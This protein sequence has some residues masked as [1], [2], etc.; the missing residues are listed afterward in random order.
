[1]T[2]TTAAIA[3]SDAAIPADGQAAPEGAV[4]SLVCGILSFIIPIIGFILAIIAIAL[5][6]N[7][8]KKPNGGMGLAGFVLGIITTVLYSLTFA[9]II[10]VMIYIAAN[11]PG[12]TS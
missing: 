6:N 11:T 9:Y 7:A 4:A 5:G 2:T 8:R 1:M 10:G 12:A 3:A